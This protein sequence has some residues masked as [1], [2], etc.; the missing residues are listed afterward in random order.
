MAVDET[1]SEHIQRLADD[2]AGGLRSP[3]E[4]EAAM[5]A[6]FASLGTII[7][8]PIS[9]PSDAS[10]RA[11]GAFTDAQDAQGY[12]E[13]GGL[14]VVSGAGDNIPVPFVYFLL[15]FDEVLQEPVYQTY[16]RDESG[17]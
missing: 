2:G 17:G 3:A 10:I 4:I 9:L 11:S 15:I 6:E 8:D 1:Q 14:A 13:R 16:I 7:S 12:L 5:E